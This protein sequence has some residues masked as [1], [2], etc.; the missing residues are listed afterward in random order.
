[1]QLRRACPVPVTD[2]DTS[3][4]PARCRQ[5]GPIGRFLSRQAARPH[6]LFGPVIGRIWVSETAR[7]NDAALDLL[8][9]R[10]GERVL[11]IG[12]GPGATVRKLADT[13]ARV[14]GVDASAAMLAAAGRRN[15]A[16]VKAG[17]VQ[18]GLGDG[19]H[20]RPSNDEIDA[21]IAVHTIY[22]WPDPHATLAEI[23]RVLRPGGRFVVAF[24][25]GEQPLP[26]RFDRDVYKAPTTNELTDW[27]TDAG[28][29]D[30]RLVRHLVPNGHVAAASAVK[31]DTGRVT[32][33]VPASGH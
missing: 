32:A 22:F 5:A 18:L 21:V 7:V 27:L 30:V 33:A 28:F 8:A 14:V 2:A 31:P 19:V 12:F 29:T 10:P 13:G 25:A 9:A 11:E 4:P 24:H 20:L 1:M 17:R 23:H 15:S 6:G 16:H 3:G 26:A